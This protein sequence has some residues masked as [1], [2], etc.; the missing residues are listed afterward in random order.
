MIRLFVAFIFLLLTA[1]A[2]LAFIFDLPYWLQPPAERFATAWREDLAL[3][4]A[5]GHF[6]P[7]WD[8]LANVEFSSNES[9]VQDWFKATASPFRTRKGAQYKLQILAIHFIDKHRYGVMIQYNWIDLK[10]K[11]TVGELARTLTIGLVY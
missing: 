4:R 6:P 10:T 11:N 7:A 1:V 5:T 2:S 3:L 9:T 8:E